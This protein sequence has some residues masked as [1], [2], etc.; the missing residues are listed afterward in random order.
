MRKDK[1]QPRI[2]YGWYILAVGMVGALMTSGSSQLFM[3]IMLK[4]LTTEF[5]WSRTAATGAITT[6]TIMAGLFSY[7]FGKL[8]D[9]YGPRLLTSVGALLTA[10]TYAAIASFS[11]LWQFYAVYVIGRVIA[12]NTVSGVVPKTAAVNWF[13][14]YRGRVMGFL[15]M[16]SPLGSSLLVF[17]AQII[18]IHHGWRFVF[19]VFALATIL[20]Q[21][22]PAALVLRRRPEDMGLV[23][24]GGPRTRVTSAPS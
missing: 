16:T 3:S 17:I 18:M 8:A 20:L 6:G 12:T 4:P 10:G 21:A 2:F 1:K 19:I 24:D 9:R 5:G 13:R 15:T 14:R 23:P 22:L 7:P 11:N